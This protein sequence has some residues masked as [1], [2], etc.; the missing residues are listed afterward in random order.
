MQNI[1]TLMV[2]GASLNVE[3]TLYKEITLGDHIMFIGEVI[4]AI[5]DPKKQTLVYHDRKYW[6]LQSLIKP[7]P[8]ER[9]RV[10][11]VMEKYK[12]RKKINTL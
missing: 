5:H 8:D 3:C 2:K 1:K 9:K 4:D 11:E 7:R 6:S 12:I 10:R